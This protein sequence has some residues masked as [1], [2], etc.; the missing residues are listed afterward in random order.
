MVSSVTTR[1]ELTTVIDAPIDLVFD[2]AR[3]LDLHARSMVASGERA[4]GGRTSGRIEQGESV[5]WRARHFGVWWT[6][7]SRITVVD[8]P[9]RFV[10]E[11]AAGPFAWFRHEHRFE[12]TAAGRTR[13]HDHWEHRSPLGPLGVL[14]DRL[15]LA[16]HMRRLLELRNRSLKAAAEGNMYG[17]GSMGLTTP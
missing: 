11:Q 3:D 14:A 2:L 4:I 12:P 13:M 16:G 9:T 6:L 8:P 1:I 5:T 7:T 15:V 10:D 17:G